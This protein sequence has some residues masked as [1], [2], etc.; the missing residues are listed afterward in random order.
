MLFTQATA[1]LRRFFHFES[2]GVGGVVAVF[3][4]RSAQEELDANRAEKGIDEESVGKRKG[5]DLERSTR[6]EP[7]ARERG[8]V[9]RERAVIVKFHVLGEHSD[10]FRFRDDASLEVKETRYVGRLSCAFIWKSEKVS[11]SICFIEVTGPFR[12]RTEQAIV[13]R[14]TAFSTRV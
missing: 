9:L 13:A 3:I 12:T 7:F 8:V 11:A 6:Y 14:L 5:E 10:G 4:F 1:C 2:V